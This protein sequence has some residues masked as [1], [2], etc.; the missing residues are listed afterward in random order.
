MLPTIISFTLSVWSHLYVSSILAYT[1][2]GT[3]F[4]L[5]P[6]YINCFTF[7]VDLWLQVFSSLLTFLVSGTGR[8]LLDLWAV[9]VVGKA[10]NLFPPFSSFLTC[11]DLFFLVC[12]FPRSELPLKTHHSSIHA[13]VLCCYG[14]RPPTTCVG[15]WTVHS[16]AQQLANGFFITN[17]VSSVT[18]SSVDNLGSVMSH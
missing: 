3:I 13:V 5:F 18:P 17:S 11:H 16:V 1:G 15:K 14:S 6:P 4:I 2:T 8:S 7:N 12:F 10:L 9:V